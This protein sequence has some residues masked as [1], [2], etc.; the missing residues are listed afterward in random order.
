MTVRL[1]G[2]SALPPVQV[3]GT[4]IEQVMLNLMLNGMEAAA[5]AS[6][7]RREVVVATTSQADAIEVTVR[8][9]GSG[10]APGVERRIF[11]PFFTTKSHGLGLGLAISRSIVECHGGR[12]WAMSDPGA[13]ATFCFSLPHAAA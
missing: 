9:T 1:E 3:D 7:T 8:D 10:F 6:G 12:L 11:T 4:Q 5:S 13:G 2:D